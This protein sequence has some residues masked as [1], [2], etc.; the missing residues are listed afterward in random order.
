MKIQQKLNAPAREKLNFYFRK[1]VSSN[2]VFDF[3]I[4][5]E[6]NNLLIYNHQ[7]SEFMGILNNYRSKI[8]TFVG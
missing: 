7:K 3:A 1:I 2:T 5:V 8:A 4:A 6:L